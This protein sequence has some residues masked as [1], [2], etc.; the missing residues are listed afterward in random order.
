MGRIIDRRRVMGGGIIQFADSNTKSL[1]VALWGG[2]DGGTA[3]LNTRVN[4]V[5]VTGVDGE[6]TYK[7]AASILTISNSQFKNSNIGSFDELQYFTELTTIGTES[8]RSCVNMTSIIIPN[9]VVSIRENAFGR[10]RSL[11]SV[12]IGKNVRSIGNYAFFSCAITSIKIPDSLT[13]LYSYVFQ[14]CS[15]LNS[16]YISD[17]EAWCR[18]SFYSYDANPLYYAHHLFLNGEKITNLIIPN[19]VNSIGQYTFYYCTDFI[20]VTI[21]NDVTSIGKDAFSYCSGLTSLTIGSSVAS[22]G[23]NP[24]RYCHKLTA[25]VVESD[26]SVFDSREDCNAVIKSSTNTLVIGSKTTIIPNSVTSIGDYAFEGCYELASIDIPNSVTSIGNNAFY[27]CKG[28]TSI[29]IPDSVTSIGTYVFYESGLQGVLTIPNSITNISERTFS[30]CKY[31]TSVTIPNSVTFIGVS[32]FDEC[33]A[34]VSVNIPNSVTGLGALA[35]WGCKAL[36]SITIPDRVT[37]IGRGTFKNCSIL[38]SVTVLATTPPTLGDSA[39]SDNKAGRKIYVPS[40][41]VEA[42]KTAAGWSTYAADIEAIP[43]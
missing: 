4:N 22:L 2:A 32:A 12:I 6:L 39:F 38:A 14:S 37:S 16:V 23:T 21:T 41:S 29:T 5:K 24:F 3:P 33:V 26:N 31:I 20:S 36:T 9:N 19:N 27:Y 40:E 28:L 10:N 13:Y 1:C 43:T 17:L 15:K 18:I 30:H 11:S 8:F 42:Y 34:L 7:Q 25:I 35:F